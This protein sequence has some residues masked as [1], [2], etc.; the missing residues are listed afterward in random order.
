METEVDKAELLMLM[1][2]SAYHKHA[3]TDQLFFED[4]I[5]SFEEEWERANV[6]IASI[7]NTPVYKWYYGNIVHGILTC[8]VYPFFCMDDPPRLT[9]FQVREAVRVIYKLLLKYDLEVDA[10]DYYDMSPKEYV[11]ELRGM[12]DT[13]YKDE[14]DLLFHVL[15]RTRR[16]NKCQ[17]K[18][19]QRYLKWN[20]EQKRRKAAVVV[21]ENRVFET[22]LSPYTAL[23]C[24]LIK[25][26]ALHFYQLAEN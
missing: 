24:K 9:K 14:I 22:M 7:L 21:I 6:N 2:T 11:L 8:I 16:M 15:F 4:V 3:G 23:G 17:V 18:S 19:V 1:L 25:K 13:A 12:E 20:R 5:G 26:R 10:K